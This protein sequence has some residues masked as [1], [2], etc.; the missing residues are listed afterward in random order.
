M[1]SC[2]AAAQSPSIAGDIDANVRIHLRFIEEARA[3]GVALLLFPELSLCG[4]ELPLLRDCLLTPDDAR[5]TP[6]RE[7]A[8]AAGM[9]VIVGAPLRDDVAGLPHIAS[10]A[11]AP[12]GT[13]AIYRKQY[14]H[15]GEERYAQPG[16]IEA[17]CQTLNGHRY[18]QAICADTGHQAHAAAAVAAGALLYLAGVLISKGAYAADAAKLQQYAKDFGIGVM[19]ANHAAPSGGYDAAG[20]SAFWCPGGDL[21]VQ[22][23]G[24]GDCLVIAQDNGGWHGRTV[25]VFL[26]QD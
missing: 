15:D 22:A 16:A 26:S 1:G 12:D 7:A 21:L 6:I 4:Y 18:A 23:G 3:Q 19:I 20:R 25:P 17:R 24:P 10:F 14:L 11:Y 2:I 9:T 13:V 8:T 5:L